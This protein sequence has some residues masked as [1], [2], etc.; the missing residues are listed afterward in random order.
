MVL[1]LSLIGLG[2]HDSKVQAAQN[3]HNRG[4]EAMNS[5]MIEKNT[6]LDLKEGCH[7]A[8]DLPADHPQVL[9]QIFTHKP[10][11]WEGSS[12]LHFRE[13]CMDYLK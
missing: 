13:T 3:D 7:V 11:V 1:A 10:N 8:Q 12:G 5:Q 9:S 6:K 4:Y 2:C